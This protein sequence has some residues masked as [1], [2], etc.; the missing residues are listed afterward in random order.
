MVHVGVNWVNV[1]V[2]VMRCKLVQTQSPGLLFEG[3]GGGYNIWVSWNGKVFQGTGR[4]FYYYLAI[5][6]IARFPFG[7]ASVR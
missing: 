6:F 1:I 4:K 2:I 3:G 7:R 5:L